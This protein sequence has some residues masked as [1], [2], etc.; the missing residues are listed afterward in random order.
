MRKN[1]KEKGKY[2]KISIIVSK[3]KKGKKRYGKKSI[4]N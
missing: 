2:I 3:E 1:S 4:P